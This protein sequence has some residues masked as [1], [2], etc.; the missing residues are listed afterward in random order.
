MKSKTKKIDPIYRLSRMT[1][2]GSIMSAV[3][4]IISIQEWFGRSL[5]IFISVIL[6]VFLVVLVK[7]LITS[8]AA[9]ESKESLLTGDYSE[10]ASKTSFKYGWVVIFLF[11]V[12]LFILNA[13]FGIDFSV[14]IIIKL[15]LAITVAVP[16]IAYLLLTREKEESDER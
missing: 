10:E 14:S 5:N 11:F 4:F 6:L 9:A 16:S 1:A 2:Y 15:S 3:I 13:M 12:L 7:W 8:R